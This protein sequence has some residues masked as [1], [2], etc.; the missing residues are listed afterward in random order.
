MLGAW[1]GHVPGS[2]KSF[3]SC[4]SN[5]PQRFAERPVT[6]RFR[7]LL[8]HVLLR[9]MSMLLGKGSKLLQ[10]SNFGLGSSLILALGG[11]RPSCGSLFKPQINGIAADIKQTAHMTFSVAFINGMQDFLT[12][13]LA[14]RG[15][16]GD[17]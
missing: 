7:P 8:C 2:H 11:S 12:E 13:I 14:V 5:S 6:N 1:L 3:F 17:G 16:H 10:V 4:E 15:R 9:Q